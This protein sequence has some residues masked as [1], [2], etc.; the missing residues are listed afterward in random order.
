MRDFQINLVRLV[1]IIYL[2]VIIP[3]FG[4][5]AVIAECVFRTIEFIST[6]ILFAPSAIDPYGLW[7]ATSH[8]QLAAVGVK[9]DYTTLVLP[10]LDNYVCNLILLKLIEFPF[11]LVGYFIYLY[12]VF[13]VYIYVTDNL[14]DVY[15]IDLLAYKS[16][17][18][19][20]RSIWWKLRIL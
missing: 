1:S 11:R 6:A 10:A 5:S 9:L 13:L 4:L 12:T 18:S 14:N 16:F 17:C 7:D 2:I 3:H 20:V 19:N 15:V 8:L